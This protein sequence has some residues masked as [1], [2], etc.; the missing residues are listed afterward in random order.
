MITDQI[1][2]SKIL[3]HL[4]NYSSLCVFMNGGKLSRVP[5]VALVELCIWMVSIG[6]RN[7]LYFMWLYVQ[8][9]A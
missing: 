1:F 9:S 4:I 8:R 2:M 5:R 3:K 6:T 7:E